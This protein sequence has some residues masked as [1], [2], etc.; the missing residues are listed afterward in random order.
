M[1]PPPCWQGWFTSAPRTPANGRWAVVSPS[2]STTR[3]C[4]HCSRDKPHN[5]C[6]RLTPTRAPARDVAPRWRFGLVSEFPQRWRPP[7]QFLNFLPL[8]QRHGSF[9]PIFTGSLEAGLGRGGGGGSRPEIRPV[10]TS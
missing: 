6:N 5:R 10:A 8:P 9:L 7:Q 4:R 1:P 2:R 3:T